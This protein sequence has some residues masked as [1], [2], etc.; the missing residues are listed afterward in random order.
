MKTIFCTVILGLFFV[1]A[2]SY[3]QGRPHL[4][5]E[6]RTCLESKIGKP[7]PGAR[8]SPGQMKAAF[9]SCGIPAP[10]GRVGGPRVKGLCGWST[11]A[12]I[13]AEAPDRVKNLIKTDADLQRLKQE[14]GCDR[15]GEAEAGAP[16]AA[17]FRSAN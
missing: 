9:D 5:D 8:P 14:R 2:S 10:Q 3:A 13:P 12:D 6:Q 4:T 15:V 11:V 16:S 1:G 17:S 7:G